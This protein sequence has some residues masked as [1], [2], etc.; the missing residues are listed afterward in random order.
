M[1]KVVASK[2]MLISRA[3][4]SQTFASTPVSHDDAGQRRP[5]MAEPEAVDSQ[6][7]MDKNLR[8]PDYI[9]SKM[10][11][12]GEAADAGV[13]D[14]H[15]AARPCGEAFRV[16]GHENMLLLITIVGVFSGL[17][18]GQS[19]F[20]NIQTVILERILPG[21]MPTLEGNTR[22]MKNDQQVLKVI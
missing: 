21:D 3:S 18:L 1:S 4:S 20:T 6:N 16:W 2:E 17:V 14:R 12:A 9:L 11:A 15:G 7:S 5:P 13:A 8:F 10:A 22:K 19:N